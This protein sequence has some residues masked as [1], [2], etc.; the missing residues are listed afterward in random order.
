M[1]M[2]IEIGDDRLDEVEQLVARVFPWRD[3]G[4]RMTHWVYKRRHNRLVRF[5]MRRY[6]V[7]S[8]VNIWGYVNGDGDIAVSRGCIPVPRMKMRRIGCLG[9]V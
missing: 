4:E 8:F 2:I 5:L 9:F 1:S 7:S 3:F 6:G